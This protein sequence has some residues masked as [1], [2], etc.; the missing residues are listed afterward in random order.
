MR[1]FL[2]FFLLCFNGF[3]QKII[4][5]PYL[6]KPGA[7]TMTLHWRTDEKGTGKVSFQENGK[8]EVFTQRETVATRDHVVELTGLKPG[9]LYTYTVGTETHTLSDSKNNYFRTFPA[10]ELS[11][12]LRIWAMGDFGDFTKQAY[13]N[14]QDAVYASFKKNNRDEDLDLWMWLGDNAYCCGRD[15]EYQKGV[16]EYFSPDLFSKTPIVSVPGNHEYYF[17]A[18]SEKTRAIPYFDIISAPVNGEAGGVPSGSKAYYSFDAG[19]V[20]FVSLDSYGLDEGRKLYDRESPQYKWL[21]RDLEERKARWTIVFLHHPPYTKRSHDSDAENDLIELRRVMVPVFDTYKV[22]MVLSGHSHTYERSYLIRNHTGFAR[23]FD[24]NTHVIQKTRGLYTRDSPPIINKS[25]GTLYAVVGSAGRLDWNGKP[26]PHPASVYANKDTGGSLLLTV[27][28]NR[29]EG[30]WMCA[31]GAV[32]DNFT[33]FKGVSRTDTLEVTYGAEVTLRASWTGNYRWSVGNASGRSITERFLK[34]TE[35]TVTDSL[36][37][38]QD[39]FVIRPGRQPSVIPHLSRMESW[40]AGAVLSGNIEVKNEKDSGWNYQVFLS[41]SK[42]DFEN[43][44]LLGET[45]ETVFSFLLPQDTEQSGSYRIRVSVPENPYFERVESEAFVVHR[46][47]TARLSPGGTVVFQPE[48]KLTL[49]LQGSLPARVGLTG[50]GEIMVTDTLTSLNIRPEKE[51]IYRVEYVKNQCGNGQVTGGGL[52]V[53]APLGNEDKWLARVYPNPGQNKFFIESVASATSPVTL[54]IFD[55]SGKKRLTR[56]L[57]TAKETVDLHPAPAGGYI[58]RFTQ[59]EIIRNIQ[60][61][62]N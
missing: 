55:S 25:E 58:F 11:R 47:A 38:L 31:D 22:D 23:D 2:L 13:I 62:K 35:V 7:T 37:Y 52:V 10:G 43:G 34:D 9:S 30:K 14:N 28:D 46:P 24:P 60:V 42:G 16:F 50:V 21:I 6:Q 57:I 33:L 53:Q 8:G 32:R 44:R 1:P 41:D 19:N 20:H 51:T 36:G 18:G 40:C 27:D 15:E 54:E 12:P 29:L 59:G 4:R 3:S 26:D 61:V 56:R 39:R 49:H 5:G 45:E 48:M 17:E